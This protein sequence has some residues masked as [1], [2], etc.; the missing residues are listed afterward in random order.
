M[1]NP[2]LMNHFLFSIILMFSISFYG[3]AQ[4]YE[5]I[6][7]DEF[8]GNGAINSDKWHHQ[9]LLPNGGSWNN[10]EIQHY[11]NREINS[12]VSAGILKIVAKK[13]PFTDQG[14]TKQFTSARLNSK[15]AFTY[16]KVDVRAKLASG[17]G[18]WPA[19]WSLGQNIIE[20][21]GFWSNSNG[22]IFWPACGELDIMEH[23]GNNQNYVQSAIHSPSSFGNTINKG[24]QFI[25]NA[26]T[27]FHVYT[28]EWTSERIIFS[29][30]DVV[31]YTY[32]P[33][34]QNADTWPFDVNQYLLLNIAILPEIS[35]DFTES[36]ME[37]DYVR[38]YQEQVL[39]TD[40]NNLNLVSTYPNPMTNLLTVK[41]PSEFLGTQLEIYSMLN[42]RLLSMNISTENFDVDVSGLRRGT[43]LLRIKNRNMTHS[44]L[45]I[46]K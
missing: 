11:T 34:V 16:G 9:T 38:V 10:G 40:D 43:Y 45:L 35:P 29:V 6:W 31:H 1:N 12:N 30:D 2:Y 5:L 15:F 39:G 37:I 7:F 44:K 19:I 8:E 32:E 27:G 26:S 13:E 14:I 46:K 23:W 22:T 28:M 25:Q 33:A 41:V 24:G 20:P 21:G 3:Q 17:V 42:Q 4:V 18:T 36:S